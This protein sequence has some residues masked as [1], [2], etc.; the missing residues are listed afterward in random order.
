MDRQNVAKNLTIKNLFAD[1]GAQLL[2]FDARKRPGKELCISLRMDEV[3]P[4]VPIVGAKGDQEASTAVELKRYH[5][6]MV[7]VAVEEEDA[8][9]TWLWT[10][11]I[12]HE[13][14]V[15]TGN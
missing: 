9:G 2:D 5:V 14:E 12:M 4:P 3:C 6:R 13:H 11:F 8:S 10:M 15:L 7:P 1:H